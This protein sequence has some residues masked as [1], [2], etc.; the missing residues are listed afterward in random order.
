MSTEYTR[1][2]ADDGTVTESYFQNGKLHR[3]DGPAVMER[4]ADGSTTE[5]YYRNG[6]FF[7]PDSPAPAIVERNIAKDET[8]ETYVRDG[9][10]YRI[11]VKFGPRSPMRKL[12]G[13]NKVQP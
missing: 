13:D 6:Q 1:G 10:V 12:H 2:I 8:T 4:K 7:R 5:K 3:D 11:D 9:R